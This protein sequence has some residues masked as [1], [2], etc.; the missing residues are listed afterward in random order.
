[1]AELTG[2]AQAMLI[3]REYHYLL[4]LWASNVSGPAIDYFA[5]EV[6]LQSIAE[7]QDMVI[8]LTIT[9]DL[10]TDPRIHALLGQ[11]KQQLQHNAEN[12]AQIQLKK[13]TQQSASEPSPHSVAGD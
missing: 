10:Q 7:Q 8:S 11:I 2:S 5:M 3:L 12:T 1:M 9:G 13:Q 6:L 4:R